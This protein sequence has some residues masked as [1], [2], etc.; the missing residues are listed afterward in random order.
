MRYQY[1][2]KH[3]RNDALDWGDGHFYKSLIYFE[4]LM[5]NYNRQKPQLK[6]YY[7]N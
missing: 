3:F 5:L 1:F 2:I 6:N 7:M 4:F